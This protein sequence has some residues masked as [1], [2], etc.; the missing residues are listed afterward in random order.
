MFVIRLVVKL[1][2]VCCNSCTAHF[3]IF[4]VSF[5][6]ICLLAPFTSQ[7]QTD[8]V[9]THIQHCIHFDPILRQNLNIC[10]SFQYHSYEGNVKSAIKVAL[11]IKVENKHL[12][13]IFQF[14][15]LT[16]S[17][18]FQGKDRKE[19]MALILK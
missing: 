11:I 18:P 10:F 17:L 8:S 9:K 14:E 4:H 5:N 3:Y 7:K 15:M 2:Y 1:V 6:E 12:S 13:S 19:T 16:G